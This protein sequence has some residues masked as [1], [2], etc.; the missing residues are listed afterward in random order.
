MGER[1]ITNPFPKGCLGSDRCRIPAILTTKAGTLVAASDA[2]WAHGQDTAGNLET[3]VARSTD[4]GLTWEQQFV[5]HFEDVVDGSERCIFSAGFIDPAIGCDREGILYLLVDLTPAYVGTF[6]GGGIVCGRESGRHANGRLALKA[7][8]DE[9]CGERVDLNEDTY[10]YYV[11]ESDGNGYAPVLGIRDHV[12]YEGYLV[13]EQMYLYR[14]GTDGIEKVMIPQ[15]DGEGRRTDH[16]I[17]GNVFFA[18]APLKAYPT[19][20]IVC[21]ISRDDGRTWSKFRLIS[22]SFS[23]G[24]FVG[25][26]PGR[27]L[28]YVPGGEGTGTS[29]ERMIFPI[30]DNHRGVEY[31]SVIYSEDQGQ[32]W[33][34]SGYADQTGTRKNGEIIKSSE[35]Q[36]VELPGGILR[37]YSRNQV[38]RIGYTEST[39]GGETWGPYHMEEQLPYCGNCMVSVI[40]YSRKLDGKVVLLA[41]YPGGDGELYH[42][43]NGIIAVGFYVETEG[44]VDWKY[45]YQVNQAPYYYSCLT[46]LADG[47]IGLLYEYEEYAMRL[48]VYNMEELMEA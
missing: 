20:H 22:E 26:C 47:R 28:S 30:Y 34:R 41:S 8:Q 16:L 29:R 31:A 7:F 40:R 37:M 1:G 21:S 17:H 42:R 10:P 46:E 27:G 38:D 39:D 19:F 11:G 45:H 14:Q 6:A 48:E 32:T 2:R 4:N 35:S 18:A 44:K 5:H 43:V 13:D 33:K 9:T 24:G 3:M 36:V 15:L 25:I 23:L 12:P